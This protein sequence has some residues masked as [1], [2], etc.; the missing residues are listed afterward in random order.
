MCH[1]LFGRIEAHVC[2]CFVAYTI[3]L[4]PERILKASASR[5]TLDRA[6]FLAE[7]IY[8]I[9]YVNPYNNRHMS[10]RLHTE[11][12]PAVLP[13][14]IFRRVTKKHFLVTLLFFSRFTKKEQAGLLAKP[15][16]LQ[17]GITNSA[18]RH[19]PQQAGATASLNPEKARG[20]S[21]AKR[22]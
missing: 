11:D 6:R 5:V 12:L 21:I 7:K 3:M 1:G 13:I 8:R 4:E 22:S 10:V 19:L 9:D 17:D 16:S 14:S 20:S 15:N 18:K 2:I